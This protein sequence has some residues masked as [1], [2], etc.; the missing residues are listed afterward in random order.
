MTKYYEE[1]QY[2]LGA[3]A[4]DAINTLNLL[5][6]GSEDAKIAPERTE[7]YVK[8][9]LEESR[10]LVKGLTEA[11]INPDYS[12]AY[13]EG[14]R[15]VRDGIADVIVVSYGW[16]V[17]AGEVNIVLDLPHER[18]DTQ[19]AFPEFMLAV[20][21][22]QAYPNEHNARGVVSA[23]ARLA[24]ALNI[25]LADDYNAV[26]FSNMSKFDTNVEDW[27]R[28]V[29]KYAADNVAINL[30]LSTIGDTTYYVGVSMADQTSLSGTFWKAGKFV[31]SVNFKEPAFS[32]QR[33]VDWFWVAP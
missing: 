9:I 31:K 6:T 28:T 11:M 15:E 20:R 14:M 10:E 21:I 24:Y 3:G 16:L 29:Q 17:S 13:K 32:A 30:V 4:Y 25:P 18:P 27:N 22:M 8:L 7:L 19:K 1:G 33:D 5:A 12:D 26:A 2:H 23:V